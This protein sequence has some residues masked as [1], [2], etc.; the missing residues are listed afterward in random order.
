MPAL[1]S[2]PSLH[3][4]V[5][6]SD[7]KYSKQ[8]CLE[9]D[10]CNCVT[11]VIHTIGLVPGTGNQANC[12]KCTISQWDVNHPMHDRLVTALLQSQLAIQTSVGLPEQTATVSD[13][14]LESMASVSKVYS[15]S[16]YRPLPWHERDC[17]MHRHRNRGHVPL[18]IS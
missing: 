9:A 3:A 14:A 6:L 18:Q 7:R 8:W 2:S 12:D 5:S 10:V 13:R 4:R 17:Y 16:T 15:L 1:T 11:L